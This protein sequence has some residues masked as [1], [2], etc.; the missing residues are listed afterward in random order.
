MQVSNSNDI[1]KLGTILSVWAHPDDES[2]SAAGILFTARQN[3]QKVCCVTAT[4][5][6]LGVQDESRWPAAELGSIRETEMQNALKEL[7]ITCHHWLG[8]KDGSCDQVDTSEAVDK[9]IK[10]I[11]H[12]EPDT[13]LTFGPTGTTGHSDHIAVGKW[14]GAALGAAKLNKPVALYHSVVSRE[15]HE[16]IGKRL[17]EQFNIYFNIDQPPLVANA[18]MDICFNLPPTACA[19]KLAAL[20]AQPSQTSGLFEH[21]TP[22]DIEMLCSCEGFVLAKTY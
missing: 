20:R 15:R 18:D 14:A 17:D 1:K 22:G 6:E 10:I 19:A 11:E 2:F 5:G 7:G 4:R 3:E 16:Q 21:T 13:V 8:Y 9:L 12:I